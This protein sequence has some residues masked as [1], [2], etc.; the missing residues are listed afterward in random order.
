MAFFLVVLQAF[1]L[2]PVFAAASAAI[3]VE[4]CVAL[5]ALVRIFSKERS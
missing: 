5:Y 3:F 2:I 4:F 1:G